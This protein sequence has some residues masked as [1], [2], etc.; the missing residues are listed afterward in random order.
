MMEY[1][2]GYLSLIPNLIVPLISCKL[3]SKKKLYVKVSNVIVLLLLAILSL[4]TMYFKIGLLVLFVNIFSIILLL[5]LFFKFPIRKCIYYGI[6]IS[7]ICMFCDAL[8]S[9]VISNN[10]LVDVSKLQNN[11]YLRII[12]SFI[13]WLLIIAIS[14]IPRLS[15]VINKYYD[16]YFIK[17]KISMK[18]T[19][20]ISII[21]LNISLL[22]LIYYYKQVDKVGRMFV[23]S[24]IIMIVILIIVLI[25]MRYYNYQYE[26]VN[27][28]ILNE[29]YYI[30]QIVKQDAEFKHNVINN[31][32]GI[33]TVS[34]RKASILIDELINSYQTEYK[35]ISNIND[36]PNGIQSIIY[37][38]AYEQNI[39]DLNLIVDNTIKSE[40]YDVLTPKQYNNLCTSIGIIFDNALDAVKETTKKVI[41]I[42]FEEDDERI[43]INIKNSFLNIIDLDENS[44]KF[45]TTK[46]DGHGIGLNY[47]YKLK[48]L[49]FKTQI[50]N[51]MFINKIVINKTKKV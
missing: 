38:K 46:R 9:F 14:F 40:L 4:I 18:T 44:E 22:F 23:F 6:V 41:F 37:K 27:K 45:K 39:D 19:A 10:V 34:N 48:T 32:L 24:G 30:K 33:K 7:I 47:I 13:V 5:S 35:T 29:N 21:V 16:N 17:M 31:L 11:M 3:L 15:V 43:F 1:I 50:L 49:E 8:S 25:I 42:E 28:K 20:I 36:L 12:L 51:N 2:I 26:Q